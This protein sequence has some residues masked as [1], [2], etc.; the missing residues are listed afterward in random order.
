MLA[1]QRPYN[2][3]AGLSVAVGIDGLGH[4]LVGLLVI[5][6]RG[7]LAYD[8]VMIGAHQ[9]DGAALEGFRAF[10]GVAHHE[11]GL[12]QAGGLF[13]DAAGVGE[14]NR[15]L[16]HQIDEL[17]ILERFDEEE[18]G[19]S[20]IFAKHL[21]DGLAHVGIEVHRIDEIHIRVLLAEVLHGRNHADK[22]F[23]KVLTAVASYEDEL[24]A[25]VKAVDVVACGLEHIDLFIGKGFVALEFIDHHVQRIDDRV[26]CDEDLAMGLFLLEVL[27]TEGRRGEVVGGD[28][29]SD[30]AVHLFGP[31]AVDVVSPETGLDMTHRNLLVE[32]GEGGSGAGSRVTMDQD[33]IRLALLE[34]V[35]HAGKH[36]GSDIVQVLPLLHDI[37]VIIRLHLEYAQH[38]V[39]HLPMLPRHAHDRLKLLRILLELLHQR[40]HLDGLRAG[41]EN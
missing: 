30:L 13:L 35:A 17:Q 14:D 39:Q 11:D 25:V 36:A 33:H 19:T 18:V 26:A 12:A 24:L 7:N 3:V 1:I 38:L 32:S 2:A 23:A 16:L 27:L 40:A 22:S 6:Q 8:E 34:Y 10:G 5:Q 20:E 21:M 4:T 37:Q 41:S 9:M 15:T 31:R 28:A 29:A